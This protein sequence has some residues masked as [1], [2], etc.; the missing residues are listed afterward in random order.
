[1]L[2]IAGAVAATLALASSAAAQS[3]QRQCITPGENEAVVAYVMP[4]LIGALETRCA[5]ALP[6]NA[7]LKT[8]SGPLQRKLEPQAD[9]AWPRARNAAQ[10]FAGTSLPVE[11]RFENIAKSAIAPTAALAIARGFD[12]ER[13]RID[14]DVVEPDISTEVELCRIYLEP[15]VRRITE[16]KDPDNPKANEIDRR[17]VPLAGYV[18]SNLMPATIR[19]VIDLLALAKVTYSYLF[20]DLRILTSSD[21]LHSLVTL[22][23][24]VRSNQIDMRSLIQ[25]FGVLMSLQWNMI[26]DIDANYPQ[27]AARKEFGA[28]KKNI[29]IIRGMNHDGLNNLDYLV[30]CV[31]YQRKSCEAL[32][33]L[34]LGPGEGATLQYATDYSHQQFLVS[35]SDGRNREEVNSS[36]QV[37]ESVGN[38]EN[39]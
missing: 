27:F 9:R 7:F 36:D 28:Y 17:Y 6:A 24:L 35:R 14:V 29:E 26:Q 32:Q 11:G 33:D 34:S 5:S 15:G 10:R 8:R 31:G 38:L 30:N 4:E 25:I 1:M 12:A 16:P 39:L 13:C 37:P 3:Q 21:V 2:R 18:G 22:E 19:D 20:H 23:M